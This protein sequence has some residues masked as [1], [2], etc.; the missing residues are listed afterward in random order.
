M[1]KNLKKQLEN[2]LF[3]E[4][5]LQKHLNPV[6]PKDNFINNLQQRLKNK[7]LVTVEY[8]DIQLF[9]IIIC[10]GLFL[11]I[12]LIW[13]IFKTRNLVGNNKHNRTL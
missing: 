8:P 5:N 12:L 2:D 13:I 11:G 1:M 3:L 6:D 7:P 9:I 10:L 4:K